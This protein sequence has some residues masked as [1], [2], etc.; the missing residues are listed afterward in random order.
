MRQSTQPEWYLKLEAQEVNDL[1]CY[2]CNHQWSSFD[3]HDCSWCE[4]EGEQLEVEGVET[5]QT[6]GSEYMPGIS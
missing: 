6:S 1:Y 3:S 2:S 4:R 5:I